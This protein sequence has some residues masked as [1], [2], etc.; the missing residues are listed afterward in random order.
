MANKKSV[1]WL[2]LFSCLAFLCTDA[3]KNKKKETA[4]ILEFIENERTRIHN[5]KA[6][7][8]NLNSPTLKAITNFRLLEPQ[9]DN[10]ILCH[11]K[12]LE[13]SPT[14]GFV[15]SSLGHIYS[16]K[17]PSLASQTNFCF[18]QAAKL[19]AKSSLAVSEWHFIGPFVIGKME[20][21]GDPLEAFG[22][23]QNVSLYRLSK[24]VKYYS[25]MVP[26]GEVKWKV[27]RHLG[28]F[29]I[30][31][32]PE[33]QWNDLVG[34]LG[35]MGITEW[36]GWAV[37]EIAI[38]EKEQTVILQCHGITTIYIDHVPLVG[39]VYHRDHL[40]VS[41]SLSRGIHVLYAKVRAK[42]NANFKCVFKTVGASFDVFSPTMIPDLV[43]GYLFSKYFSIPVANFHG[44]KWLKNIGV[45]L[46][47]QSYGQ[48][49]SLEVTEKRNV[50]PGQIF[51]IV[52]R[53]DS[54]D[55]R[56]TSGCYPNGIDFVLE[57]STSEGQ[58]EAAP[59]NLR[60]RKLDQT[61][62]F[63]FLDHDGSVQQGA[64]IAPIGDC[65][66]NLCSVLLTLHGTSV[67][68]QNQA[69]SYKRM[70]GHEFQFGLEGIWLL[71]PTR[72]GAHN[73][74]GPGALTAMTALNRLAEI[75]QPLT[76]LKN[77][78][79]TQHVI[80]TGHSMGGHGAWHLGT[81]F[82]D[83]ALGVI[84]LAGWIKKE[85]YG[86]SNLFFRH[87]IS[88][89]HTDPVVKA[90]M[91]ATITENDADRHIQNLKGIP[92]LARIG[93]NDRTVHPYFARRMYRL[94]EELRT[95]VNYTELPGKEHWW[96]DTWSTN[97]GGA[98]H[99]KQLRK[100]SATY[101]VIPGHS[102]VSED[103]CSADSDHCF[104]S[105]DDVSPYLGNRKHQLSVPD[106]YTL[107]VNNPAIGESIHGVHIIQQITP[108]RTSTVEIQL[109]KDSVRLQTAN[110]RKFQLVKCA[111]QATE[112]TT[113][114]II[115]DNDFV[116]PPEFVQKMIAS[117][118]NWLI[119]REKGE[120]KTCP[121][122]LKL[123][124]GPHNYGPARRV[125]EKP[126]VIIAGTQASSHMNQLLLHLAVYV[127]NLFWITS[128][129]QA[130]I[131]RDADIS[132][133]KIKN[134]NVIIIGGP[135]E[136][137]LTSSFLSSIPIKIQ[138]DSL[139]LEKC[140]FRHPQT[141]V[142]S[143]APNGKNHLALMLFGNSQNALL[144]VISL[145]TP[146]IPPMSRSPFSNLVPDF[147]ITG[148][149]FRLKGPGGLSCTGFWGNHWE[150]RP[151]IS[152][153]VCHM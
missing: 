67:P 62:L 48:P 125:A 39:D 63:S 20:L 110:V 50:A 98:V 54:T 65:P 23:I 13:A 9:S 139:V 89:S 44:S 70:V 93:A 34:S 137:S 4:K 105:A 106:S 88:T 109:F 127:A 19:S 18:K 72:H 129:T 90:L 15:W 3:S 6:S 47:S 60:C 114:S 124:R 96:W 21:D 75:V 56:L 136:N 41:I 135:K 43:E 121:G 69:D 37:G 122:D 78:I 64:A 57:I 134:K 146:T 83:R 30:R 77:K 53:I 152:S 45:S 132:L 40:M 115:V 73:W 31:I 95:N 128:D 145:A 35:S 92:V 59:I 111:N 29:L 52:V 150:F 131:V 1:L 149:D 76:W 5:K 2:I 91:E 49:F 148:P 104:D 113:N 138:D 144:D 112:W 153:C 74:E 80:F 123:E 151:D 119:C 81:H 33:L 102:R 107:V 8:C 46:V 42:V 14:E 85:E 140:H 94:L 22:G 79:S 55:D 51:P 28:E 143:L 61:F 116:V 24:K 100:F 84:S 103:S 36:Q 68:A 141:G 10:T 17:S 32:S 108:M 101:G 99:D 147:M 142:L 12:F 7:S 66:A 25:E 120:W 87:D 117:P 86:D 71:A 133:E 130:P 118:G 38:N 82:P 126:F 97:D 16:Q 58:I 26:G 11:L 27:Y